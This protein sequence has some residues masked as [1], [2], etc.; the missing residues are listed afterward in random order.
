MM[1]E[2]ITNILN[3]HINEIICVYIFGS[4]VEERLRKDSDIDIAFLAEKKLNNLERWDVAFAL[5]EKLK[6]DV[7]LIDLQRASTVIKSQIISKGQCIYCSDV[8][9]KDIFEMYVFSDYARLNE[10]RKEIVEGIRKDG[11]VYAR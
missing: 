6:R 3:G 8:N 11:F 4:F 1:N 5:S 7:D 10:E 2:N 9:K